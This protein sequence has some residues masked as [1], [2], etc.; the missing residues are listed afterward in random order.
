MAD[1]ARPKL[2]EDALASA[3]ARQHAGAAAG[4]DPGRIAAAIDVAPGARTPVQPLDPQGDGLESSELK[5][6]ND[7]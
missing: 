5:A 4:L 2:I 7:V 1:Q 6:G 3:I